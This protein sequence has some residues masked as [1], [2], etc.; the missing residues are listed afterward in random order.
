MSEPSWLSEAWLW[1]EARNSV[2]DKA[3]D[4]MRPVPEHGSSEK[5]GKKRRRKKT[6]GNKEEGTKQK[7]AAEESCLSW[8]HLPEGKFVSQSSEKVLR[9]ALQTIGFRQSNA[10]QCS[11]IPESFRAAPLNMGDLP[12]VS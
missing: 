4:L 3:T 7:R 6:E 5:K 2:Q 1:F 12:L 9:F 11:M 8:P 10:T